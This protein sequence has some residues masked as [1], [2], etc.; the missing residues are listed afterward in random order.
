MPRI[1]L[2]AKAVARLRAPTK[3]G[4]PEL[5]WDYGGQHSLRGFGVLCSGRSKTKNFVAQRDLPS[6][7]TRRVT[8]GGVAEFKTIDAARERAAAVLQ[9]MRI[10]LDP[11]AKRRG[12]LTLREA[13]DAYIKAGA[14]LL[15]PRTVEHYRDT[16]ESHLSDWFDRPLS[17]ITHDMVTTRH[18]KIAANVAASHAKAA[19]EAEEL[20]KARAAKAKALGWSEAAARHRGKA[21]AAAQR[22]PT[23][24]HTAANNCMRVLRMLHNFA[25]ESDATLG[26]NPVRLKKWFP[27][28]RRDRRVEANELEK[29]YKAVMGLEN[30]V[31]RDY[32]RLLLLTGLRRREAAQ[33]RWT[34]VDLQKRVLR[35]SAAVAKSGRKLNLPLSNQL[36]DLLV[37]RRAVGDSKYIFPANSRSEHIEEPKAPLALVAAAC[38]INVSAH[39]LRRT[40]ASTAHGCGVSLHVLKALLNHAGPS[41]TGDVTAAYVGI[42]EDEMADAA[43]KVADKLS[44]LC[45]IVAPAG[46]NVAKLPQ[47]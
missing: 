44:E 25:K 11:K 9:D 13:L 43:Q 10:G 3:S 21:E 38:G 22:A 4:K 46:A 33:L 18:Q 45:G 28:V 2:T 40:Y 26:P 42:S 7:R 27:L 36:H 5:F 31:A 1:K 6:G 17:E 35:I 24:G 34:D 30:P 15:R 8:I 29:F 12:A 41:P 20:H 37:S 19:A 32:L 23:P 16:V 14:H 47:R 39:D